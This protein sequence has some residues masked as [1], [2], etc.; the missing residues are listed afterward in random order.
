MHLSLHYLSQNCFTQNFYGQPWNATEPDCFGRQVQSTLQQF[1]AYF[2]DNY[3][4]LR[5]WSIVCKESKL[6]GSAKYVTKDSAGNASLKLSVR[7][8]QC[9]MLKDKEHIFKG[10]ISS[11]GITVGK[12]F[13][14]NF[15]YLDICLSF[16]P[17]KKHVKIIIP[18][19]DLN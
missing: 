8:I 7:S 9:K 17:D 19:F 5:R 13:S 10:L 12:W 11:L 18:L 14:K 1:F 3:I 16:S 4:T 15:F 6:R 2:L